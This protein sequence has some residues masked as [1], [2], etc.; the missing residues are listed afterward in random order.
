MRLLQSGS[1][2]FRMKRQRS[3]S[4][5]KTAF[6]EAISVL[7]RIFSSV[8]PDGTRSLLV[9][10]NGI[11]VCP[12]TYKFKSPGEQLDFVLTFP[13]LLKGISSVNLIEDCQDNCFSFLG[14][15]WTTISIKRSMMLLPLQRMMNRQRLW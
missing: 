12:D 4:G 15:S 3:F 7:I 8:Y 11:P 1:L 9:S 5:L 10:S 13:P 14:L 2:S 6:P